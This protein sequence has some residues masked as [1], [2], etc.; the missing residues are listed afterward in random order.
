MDR[1]RTEKLNINL[2]KTEVFLV[3]QKTNQG[4]GIQTVLGGG[5]TL[6]FQ[7]QVHSLGM[8]LDITLS[9][10]A[11]MTAVARTTFAQLNLV[12]KLCP[13]LEM[14]ELATVIHA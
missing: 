10:N 8:L 7:H 6:P 2:D 13:F 9:L 14:S 12:C 4:I 5:F 1:R 3:G 11:Q